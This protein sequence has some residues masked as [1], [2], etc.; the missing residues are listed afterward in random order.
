[1]RRNNYESGI[2]INATLDDTQI[3]A[4]VAKFKELIANN[5]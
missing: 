5:G 4:I 3:D 1:L 2:I